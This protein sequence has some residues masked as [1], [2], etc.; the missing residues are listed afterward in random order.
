MSMQR[1][2]HISDQA[3]ANVTVTPLVVQ[4]DFHAQVETLAGQLTAAG[5]SMCWPI[6]TPV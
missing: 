3:P 4:T 5:Q 1:T 2:R 6:G